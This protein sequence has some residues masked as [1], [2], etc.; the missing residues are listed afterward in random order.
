MVFGVLNYNVDCMNCR[1]EFLWKNFS[2]NICKNNELWSKRTFHNKTSRKSA[3]M[4]LKELQYNGI[5][6]SSATHS[7]IIATLLSS[8]KST[9]V[10]LSQVLLV[11]HKISK[12]LDRQKLLEK[13]E[14]LCTRAFL[15]V[16][17]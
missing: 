12:T 2:S 15:I 17:K 3:R 10:T 7:D 16:I 4:K 5:N 14:C 9:W 6:K 11:N 1:E 13:C 8:Q